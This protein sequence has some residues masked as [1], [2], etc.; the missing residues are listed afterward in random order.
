MKRV[1]AL[2]LAML[3]VLSLA[4]CQVYSGAHPELH[5]VAIH[6]ILGGGGGY[7]EDILVLE[8]DVFGRV[9]FAYVGMTTV[10]ADFNHSVLAVLV[11]QRSTRRY[12]Y[13][14]DGINI[15]LHEIDVPWEETIT[16]FLD[17][18]FVMERFSEEQLEQLQAK[19]SWNEEL[20][21]DR[22][23]RVRV[24]RH[25][26]GRYMTRVP[27][28]RLREAVAS[29]FSALSPPARVP[30]MPL[31]MDSNGNVIHFIYGRRFD[32]E[33]QAS[34]FFPASLFMFDRNGSLIEGAVMELY[35]LWDYRDQLREFKELNGWAFTY[36]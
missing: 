17:E 25:G 5:V 7:R 36:R 19:N 29:V 20:N 4:G 27:D 2:L 11:A 12:S 33:T 31:T 34:L 3:M 9:M 16:D 23:F 21:E 8:E 28:Q 30:S 14:Y 32:R 35:D 18:A 22:F 13:F 26:K 10:R 1:L 6:S 15:I 24:S